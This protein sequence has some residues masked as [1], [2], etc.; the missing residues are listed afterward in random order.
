MDRIVFG[1]VCAAFL[2]L[3]SASVWLYTPDLSARAVEQAAAHALLAPKEVGSRVQERRAELQRALLRV[4]ANPSVSKTLDGIRSREVPSG[5]ALAD[6]RALLSEAL[7]QEMRTGLVV[8]L[9]NGAGAVVTRGIVNVA[10][11]KMELSALTEAGGSGVL[12]DAFGQPHLFHSASIANCHLILGAPLI[13]DAVMESI[14]KED[15]L[16]ALGLLRDGKVQ[17]ASGP[18][19]ASVERAAAIAPSKERAEVVERG[20]VGRFGPFKLPFLTD[21]DLFGGSAPLAVASRQ[22]LATTPYELVA[23]VSTTPTMVALGGPQKIG[24]LGFLLVAGLGAVGLALMGSRRPKAEESESDE[25]P[26]ASDTA[27][28]DA[29]DE[30]PLELPRAKKKKKKKNAEA[31]VEAVPSPAPPSRAAAETTAKIAPQ[32]DSSELSSPPF[33]PSGEFQA[34]V[35][36]GESARGAAA[37]A[38][39]EPAA[40]PPSEEISGP[41]GVPPFAEALFGSVQTSSGMLEDPADAKTIAASGAPETTPPKGNRLPNGNGSDGNHAPTPPPIPAAGGAARLDGA[42]LGSSAAESNGANG[43]NGDEAHF[44]DVFRNFVAMRQQCGEPADGLTYEKFAQ[45]LQKNR[46]Q[47]ISRY[48]CRTVRFQ[49]YVKEGKAALKA[50][51]VKE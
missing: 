31:A 24:V 37:A 47:L 15:G 26:V 29:D 8:G 44:Q 16:S 39:A 18:G 41:N 23:V 28:A 40:A 27:A 38:A 10:P 25:V 46:E 4:V 14:I 11:D 1:I 6:V 3:W 13:S 45:K 35:S 20:M 22:P 36:S 19:I 43:V 42:L 5:D 21:G 2:A 30:A 33:A 48:N 51:P 49:V 9:A 17:Q 7:P 12:R 50:T 32:R 34:V